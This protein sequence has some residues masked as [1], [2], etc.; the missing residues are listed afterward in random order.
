MGAMIASER[1]FEPFRHGATMFAHGYT[2]GGHPVG[3]AVQAG[4]HARG[5]LVAAVLHPD[6]GKDQHAAGCQRAR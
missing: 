5:D 2:W 4:V 1:L 6:V 3:A